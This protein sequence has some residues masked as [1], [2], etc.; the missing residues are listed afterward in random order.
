MIH[1]DVGAESIRGLSRPGADF[2]HLAEGPERFSSC[3]GGFIRA[4][5]SNDDDPK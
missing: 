2:Q 1:D 4:G 5:V 3:L